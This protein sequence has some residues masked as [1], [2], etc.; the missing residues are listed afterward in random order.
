MEAI[1][2]WTVHV[3]ITVRAELRIRP[4]AHDLVRDGPRDNTRTFAQSLDVAQSF[5]SLLQPDTVTI[6]F[7]MIRLLKSGLHKKLGIF[8]RHS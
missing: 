8:K 4:I 1:Q 5:S 6:L 3:E 2:D 7:R